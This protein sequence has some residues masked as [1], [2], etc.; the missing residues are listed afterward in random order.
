M[1]SRFRGRRAS[2]SSSV[3]ATRKLG[4]DE[5]EVAVGL[6]PVGL[7]GLDEAVEV[8]TRTTPTTPTAT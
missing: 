7:G 3:V 6:E 1:R 8:G 2:K 5:A 4:E